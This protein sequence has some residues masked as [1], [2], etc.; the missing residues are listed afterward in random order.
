MELDKLQ[1]L[2]E[3]PHRICLLSTV[4][5]QSNPNSAIFGSTQLNGEQIIIGMGNNHSLDNLRL[6]P[7]A[8]LM[9]VIPGT[10]ILSFQGVRLYLQCKTI[11]DSGPLLDEIRVEAS[12]HAGKAAARMIQQAL[13][14]DILKSR[15]L[16]EMGNISPAQ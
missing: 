12:I 1:Q 3:N 11:E 13:S 8:T 2:L 5:Q 4:D 16:I 9:V 7:Q 10:S 6:N 14:F 15:D